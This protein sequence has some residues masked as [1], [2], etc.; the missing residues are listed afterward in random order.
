MKKLSVI[1]AFE[2]L[3]RKY[4]QWGVYISFGTDAEDY[5]IDTFVKLEEELLK[6][7]PYLDDEDY[8]LMYDGCGLISCDSEKEA[9]IIFN[10]T[11]GDDGPT[12]LNSYNGPVSVYALVIGPNGFETENT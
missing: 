12:K 9:Y 11:V 6:A 2:Y 1:H 10:Q 5:D 4:K 7:M 3:C 8:Q